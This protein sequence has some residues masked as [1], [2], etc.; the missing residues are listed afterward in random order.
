MQYV[1]KDFPVKINGDDK[2]FQNLT[3]EGKQTIL[4]YEL[5]M[6]ICE[7]SETEKLLIKK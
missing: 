7:D 3:D 4:N 5:I 6:N 2:F 1:N